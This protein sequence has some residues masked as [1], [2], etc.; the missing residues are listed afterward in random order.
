MTQLGG[1]LGAHNGGVFSRAEAIDSGE[2]DRSL[3]QA[4]R[5]GRIVR[6]R[7]GMYV[8]G[9]VHGSCDNTGRH[10]LLARAALAAQQGEV[11]LTGISA[12]ALHGFALHDQDLSTAH[13]LRLDAGAGRRSAGANHHRRLPPLTEA[14][15]GVFGGVR[16]VTPARAVWEVACLSSLEGAVVTADAALHADPDLADSLMELQPRFTCTPGS[17]TARLAMRLADHR[18]ESA[19]ES[20]TRVGC[21]RFDIPMPDLQVEVHDRAGRLVGR[22]D[23]GWR[24]FRHLGEFDGKVKYE[25]YRRPGESVTECVVREKQR[26]D[27]VRA[28]LWGMTRFVWSTV[29]PAALKRTMTDLR[30]ALHQSRRLYVPVGITLAG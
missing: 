9:E 22:S 4:Q 29:M 21:Y 28:E 25:K 13:L 12:A 1:A 6:L 2:T 16:A 7:R 20:V 24:E 26:E 23:L 15:I 14:D 5:D 27:A 17:R 3:A 30:Y 8:A 18:S 19:G 11:V 10:L